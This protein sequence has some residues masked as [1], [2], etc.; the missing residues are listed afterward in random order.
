VDIEPSANC[1]RSQWIFAVLGWAIAIILA[2][3]PMLLS[4][5]SR[6]QADPGDTRFNGYLLEH[7]FRWLTSHDANR[8]LWSPPFFYP[9]TNVLAYSDLMISFA[10]L[11]WIWRVCGVAPD[12][13][14][15][16]WMIS[17]TAVNYALAYWWLRSCLGTR[18]LAGA[19][20]A[21]IVAA[22]APRITQLGHQQLLC[23]MY[24]L[25]AIIALHRIFTANKNRRWWI[26]VFGGCV[27]AQF[28][29]GFY[30]GFF[31]VLLMGIAAIAALFWQRA[32]QPMLKVVCSNGGF[33]AFIVAVMGLL[34]LLPAVHYLAELREMG[35]HDYSRE[36]VPM[37]APPAAWIYPGPFSVVYQWFWRFPW[38]AGLPLPVEQSLGVGLFTTVVAMCGLWTNRRNPA[39]V[40]LAVCGVAI[41]ALTIVINGHSAWRFIYRFVPA[42]GAIRAPARMGLWLLLPIAAGVAMFVDWLER[43]PVANMRLVA[44]VAICCIAEQIVSP[45]S[46]D[47]AMMH[48]RAARIAAAIP[49]SAKAFYCTSSDPAADVNTIQL[50]A[51]WASLIANVPTVNG[52][53][54][55]V[56]VGW[57][58]D[59]QRQISN[60]MVTITIEKDGHA[61]A[62]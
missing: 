34:L 23:Q 17:V 62:D 36:I 3:Y 41:I 35:G 14:F 52:Y 16:F 13:A 21:I 4:G 20:G 61:H 49:P 26:A 31:L 15:Q 2:H 55:H 42:A 9:H 57:P 60:G 18:P 56:P 28:W 40:L 39:V 29:G 48:D 33:I 6:M 43:R 19:L 51:M 32:R 5:L 37:L 22:G 50:D 24:L 47:K 59:V 11:Y 46:F 44:L 38:F 1:A 12:T 8:S 30:N 7:S 27:V 25:L 54:G 53:S 10:P 58:E 45:P